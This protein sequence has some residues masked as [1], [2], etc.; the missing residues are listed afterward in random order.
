MCL[1]RFKP[2]VF[3]CRFGY[4]NNLMA[5]RRSVVGCPIVG[6]SFL[7]RFRDVADPTNFLVGSR[8][9]L[10]ARQTATVLPTV[11]CLDWHL[12]CFNLSAFLFYWNLLFFP[13]VTISKKVSRWCAWT[14]WAMLLNPLTMPKSE[15]NAKSWSD[16][17]QKS[18][19]NSWK[20]WWAMVSV[21]RH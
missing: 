20:S 12:T 17:A 8:R 7:D 9:L 15:V 4:V 19:S 3:A 18:S 5:S 1:R 11:D 16:L 10:M 13:G 14:Y 21:G 2:I 6:R